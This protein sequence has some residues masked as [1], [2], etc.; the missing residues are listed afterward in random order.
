MGSVAMNASGDIALGYSVS[1]ATSVLPGIRVTGRNDGDS[2]GL[3]TMNELTIKDGEGVQTWTQRWGDYSSM[4]VDP[5]DGQT[6]WYT[7]QI[8]QSNG[9]WIT[10][11]GH[12]SLGDIF[13]DGFESGATNAWSNTNP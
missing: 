9:N 5:A 1:D 11:V 10:W 8:V 6:F 3:M 4:N 13:S 2:L 7:N 12:F